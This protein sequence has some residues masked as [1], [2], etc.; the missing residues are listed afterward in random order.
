MNHHPTRV[1][2]VAADVSQNG[3][4]RA[5]S[6]ARLAARH[7]D[8][9]V[10]GTNFG[11]GLWEPLRGCL[12][13]DFVEGGRWPGYARAMY[14]L[15]RRCRGDVLIAV[16]PLVPSLGVA[17]LQRRRRGTPVVLDID[18]DEMA[19][20]PRPPLW[21]PFRVA[22]SL[23]RPHGYYA[24][25]AIA[26]AI[27]SADAITVASSGLQRL[28]GGT[29]IPHTKDLARMMPRPDL[30]AAMRQRMDLPVDRPVIMFAGTP[31]APK[32]VDDAA[33]AVTLM[34]HR[35]VLV[36]VGVDSDGD[37]TRRFPGRHPGVLMR[38]G[39]SIDDAHLPLYA[40]DI[41]VVPQRAEP[42]TR[43]QMPAKIV[44]AMALARPIVATAVSDLPE[45]LAEGRG[46]IVPPSDPAALARAFDAILDDPAAARAAGDRARAWAL[47]NVS[48]TAVHERLAGV[49]A[50]AGATTRAGRA[51]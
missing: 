17:L 34:R 30:T 49:I 27:E 40:A 5:Y 44:E 48:E 29:L 12:D 51:G 43:L 20:R 22:S 16:K 24:T 19:F 13:V 28:Y 23:T 11:S 6:L 7:F 41:V 4:G 14:A 8:V 18:D 39:G 35:A 1:T 46:W 25:R 26:S 42:H 37:Y 31:R 50:R 15:G 32:G 2:I 47:A 38:P 3:V 36:V 9:Q 33:L 45:Y 10:I 21:S